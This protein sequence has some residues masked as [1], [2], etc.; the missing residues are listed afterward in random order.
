[1]NL[2]S[3]GV[4]V[5]LC[6]SVEQPGWLPLRQLLWPHCATA[7][8]LIE[9]GRFLTQPERFVQLVAYAESPQPVGLVEASLREDYVNGTENSPVAFLEG[10]YVTPTHRRQGV[11]RR[12]VAAVAEWAAARGCYE[13]ASDAAL[14]NELSHAVHRSLGFVET[15][16]VVYFRKALSAK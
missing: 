1:M 7:E 5:E 13:F 12:L 2:V 6:A 14:E 15:E 11:A 9:M 10:L 4:T 3:L 8:H 16:R